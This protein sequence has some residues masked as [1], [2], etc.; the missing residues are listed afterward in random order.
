MHTH[1]KF[2]ATNHRGVLIPK[3]KNLNLDYIKIVAK[4]IFRM[5]IKGRKGEN[6]ENEYTALPP[7]MVENL[8][9]PIPINIDGNFDINI[10]NDIVEKHTFINEI[11][12]NI[13]KYRKQISEIDIETNND[14]D[15]CIDIPITNEKYFSLSRGKR[16]TKK[17]ID[18]NKGNIP[19][20]SSSKKE[21]SVLGYIDEKYLIKNNLI[22]TSTP[23]ILFNLDGSVGHCFIRNAEKYSFIDVVASLI[24][25]NKNID[26]EYTLYKLREAIAA[27]GANYQT[28]LYFNK[29]NNYNISISYPI[30][31]G[32]INL[33]RQK[34]IA[35]K[36]KKIQIIKNNILAELN[37]ILDANI[38][39]D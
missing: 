2:S 32:Q 5:N 29:I 25:Q 15:K 7:F 12:A 38:S 8:E 35:N 30:C 36:Y 4:P 17:E 21:D 27:T 20:Y 37:K 24:P 6:G 3:I 10:Q 14:Y 34:E 1:S 18:K 13:I 39:Y 11:K 31:N 26:I 23:S 9:I 22:L 16:I 28:K 19:V 33:E